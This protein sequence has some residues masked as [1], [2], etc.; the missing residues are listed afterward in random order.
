MANVSTF[1]E[2]MSDWCNSVVSED[3]SERCDA[4]VVM[5]IQKEII[6]RDFSFQI[7]K[8]LWHFSQHK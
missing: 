5:E 6:K 8:L 3:G 1:N 4:I 2:V 7:L